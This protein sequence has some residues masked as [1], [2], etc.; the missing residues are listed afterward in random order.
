MERTNSQLSVEGH[1]TRT[2]LAQ[3]C[4]GVCIIFVQCL[5]KFLKYFFLSK[6]PAEP[7]G[8]RAVRR[9]SPES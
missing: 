8:P 9:A 3:T 4:V 6:L 5:I 1:P 2:V 7:R